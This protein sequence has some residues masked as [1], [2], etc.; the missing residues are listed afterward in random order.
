MLFFDGPSGTL[1]SDHLNIRMKIVGFAQSA[2]CQ[3]QLPP[4]VEGVSLSLKVSSHDTRESGV[5]GP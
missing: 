1:C 3:V 5:E 2:S 4:G